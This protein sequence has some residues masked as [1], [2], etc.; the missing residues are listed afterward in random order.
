M[1]LGLLGVST[2]DIA[3]DYHLSAASMEAMTAWI[4]ATYPEALDAMTSQPPE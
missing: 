1:V 4:K 2:D 3:D